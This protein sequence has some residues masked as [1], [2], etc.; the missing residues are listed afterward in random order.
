MY[1]KP[2]SLE[3]VEKVIYED[4]KEKYVKIAKFEISRAEFVQFG[5]SWMVKGNFSYEITSKTHLVEFEYE[6]RG[7]KGIHNRT[8]IP[9]IQ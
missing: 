6:V 7:D 5:S 1:E 2:V 4:I 3:E 9:I 8:F